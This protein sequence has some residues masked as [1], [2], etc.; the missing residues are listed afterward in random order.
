MKLLRLISI[1]VFILSLSMIFVGL[2]DSSLNQK[3]NEQ[4]RDMAR[5]HNDQTIE[6]IRDEKIL[7]MKSIKV[8]KVEIGSKFIS[9]LEINKDVI[10]WISIENTR[11]DYPVVLGFDN[12]HYLDH[13]FYGK[14][15]R[16]GT[17]FMDFRNR[18]EKKHLILYGHNMRD[19]SMFKDLIK[20]K[21][22][23]FF[24]DN[25]IIQFDFLSRNERWEIFSAYVTDTNFYY[26]ETSFKNN[27]EFTSFIDEIKGKSKYKTDIYPEA[28]DQILTLSTCTYDF[29]DARFVIHARK[30]N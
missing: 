17:I 29:S 28:N 3:Q 15:S 10:G 11:V 9:L 19:G 20:Y 27:A 30:I 13:D 6:D 21:K 12:E 2:R 25:P 16:A 1:A 24:Y 22:E 4:I 18:S 5:S 14:K 23:S 7:E 8:P 26:I